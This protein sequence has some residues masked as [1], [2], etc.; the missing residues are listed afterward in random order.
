VSGQPDWQKVAALAAVGAAIVAFFAYVAPHS[1]SSPPP[2]VSPTANSTPYD[3]PSAADSAPA[4][5]PTSDPAATPAST[6][7]QGPPA[8]CTE[9][10]SAVTTFSRTEGTTR[11][12]QAAAAQQAYASMMR[13]GLDASGGP[14]YSIIVALAGDF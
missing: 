9:A 12:S 13:A 1:A 10:A 8:G 5:T 4:S 2:H 14:A 7:T 11:E 3:G 6:I